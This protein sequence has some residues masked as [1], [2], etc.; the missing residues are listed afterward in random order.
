MK[1]RAMSIEPDTPG[2]TSSYARMPRTFGMPLIIS[3]TQLSQVA[4][5]TVEHC[6]RMSHFGP[7]KNRRSAAAAPT[8]KYL[9]VVNIFLTS[10]GS[11][12]LDSFM[13]SPFMK[14]ESQPCELTTTI[15]ANTSGSVEFRDPDRGP[16]FSCAND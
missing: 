3:L 14:P 4:E 6:A 10:G 13:S 2:E 16:C 15:S 9:G 12:T 5:F 7:R 11:A 8:M 1:S